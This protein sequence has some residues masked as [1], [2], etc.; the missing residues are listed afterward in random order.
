MLVTTKILVQPTQNNT[1]ATAGNSAA[2]GNTRY[3]YPGE[4]EITSRALGGNKIAANNTIIPP[5]HLMQH[6]GIQQ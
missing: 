6:S 2:E 1:T 5:L 3:R 4:T